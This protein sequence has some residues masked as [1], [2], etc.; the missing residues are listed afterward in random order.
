MIYLAEA[1]TGINCIQSLFPQCK[2][3]QSKVTNKMIIDT[4]KTSKLIK[5]TKNKV[6]GIDLTWYVTHGWKF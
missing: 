2:L 4:K 5:L 3:Q 1:I 6:K